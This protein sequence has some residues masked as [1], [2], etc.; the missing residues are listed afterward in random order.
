MDGLVDMLPHADNAVYS[1]EVHEEKSR[2]MEGTRG[3]WFFKDLDAWIQ[4]D[5]SSESV[6]PIYVLSGPAGIGKSTVA[7]EVARRLDDAKKLGG[8]FFFAQGVHGLDSL[9]VP[10]MGPG[11]SHPSPSV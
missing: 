10:S 7:F 3:P 4:A 9:H 1:H 6:S 8:S 5:S 11:C 2:L